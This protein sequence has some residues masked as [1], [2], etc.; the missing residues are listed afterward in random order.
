MSIITTSLTAL[1]IAASAIAPTGAAFAAPAPTPASAPTSHAQTLSAPAGITSVNWF[2][3]RDK[4]VTGHATPGT[5][6]VRITGLALA[7]G[8]YKEGA[9]A[10]DGS[11][12]VNLAP[13]A[14]RAIPLSTLTATAVGADGALGGAVNFRVEL[15]AKPAGATASTASTALAA[16]TAS[17]AAKKAAS[18]IQVNPIHVGA[19][20]ISGQAPA[21]T[22]EIAADVFGSTVFGE[23]DADGSFSIDLDDYSAYALVGVTFEV[24]GSTADGSTLLSTFVPVTA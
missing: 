20:T 17:F 21:G 14:S 12:S 19:A 6:T 10:A 22:T 18:S 23:V 3:A 5:K 9:V 7:P 2:A 16:S 4:V 1:A 24:W 8:A 15:G 13:F 11:F